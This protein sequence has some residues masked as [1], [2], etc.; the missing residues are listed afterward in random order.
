ML[1]HPSG[2]TRVIEYPRLDSEREWVRD[3]LRMAGLLLGHQVESE[4]GREAF[5]IPPSS[6]PILHEASST[7]HGAY[8]YGD[9]TLFYDLGALLAESYR[10]TNG[11]LVAEQVSK[12]IAL[13]EFTRPDERRLFLVPGV[14]AVADFAAAETDPLAYYT[15]M[16]SRELGDRFQVAAQYFAMGFN[17]VEG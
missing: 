14:E 6:R 3:G 5:R 12:N 16:L 11:R 17:E 13:V 7:A 4:E 1:T 10:A 9:D 8:S 15:D 2:Q